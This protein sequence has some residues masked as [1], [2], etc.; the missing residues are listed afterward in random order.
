MAKVFKICLQY[1][2]K[3]KWDER[4]FLKANKHYPAGTYFH[5]VNNR[6]T[7]TRCEIFSKITINI[8]SLLL[9][10]NVFPTLF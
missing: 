4:C 9:T 2:K 1:L 7:R 5:K 10:L 3:E 6:N 8:V